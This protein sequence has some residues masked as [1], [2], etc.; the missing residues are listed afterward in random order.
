MRFLLKSLILSRDLEYCIY[1]ALPFLLLLSKQVASPGN[2]TIRSHQY[3]A[4]FIYASTPGQSASHIMP[5]T[6]SNQD[7][8]Y[9]VVLDLCVLGRR[10]KQRED[11]Q[12][13]EVTDRNH[14]VIS[15]Q[16]RV[17]QMVPRNRRHVVCMM[18]QG[19]IGE[20]LSPMSVSALVLKIHRR[21]EPS[22]FITRGFELC[23]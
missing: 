13:Q 15:L 20:L 17:R 16:P 4:S 6:T 10:N 12:I 19:P 23:V 2:N 18:H 7:H 5:S 1:Q 8:T 9:P 22:H 14:V 21:V 11:L 3:P